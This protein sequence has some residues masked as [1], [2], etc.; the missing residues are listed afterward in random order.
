[1][2][3]TKLLGRDRRDSPGALSWAPLGGFVGAAAVMVIRTCDGIV[4]LHGRISSGLRMS[5]KKKRSGL[6][7]M[8]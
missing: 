3:P 5:Q 6:R 7:M 8:L 4:F 1:M 2:G